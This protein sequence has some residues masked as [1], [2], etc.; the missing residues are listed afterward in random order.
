MKAE[1]TH[2][3]EE[4]DILL[5]K[6]LI[7]KLIIAFVVFSLVFIFKQFVIRFGIEQEKNTFSTINIAGR[8]RMLSQK[9]VKDLLMI[10]QGGGHEYTYYYEKD[11]ETSLLQWKE[12]QDELERR[13]ESNSFFQRNRITIHRMLQGMKDAHNQ[14]YLEIKLITDEINYVKTPIDLTDRLPK[15]LTMEKKI[16]VKF[17]KLVNQYELEAE[18]SLKMALFLNVS[19][20]WGMVAVIAYVLIK[21][22]IPL[23]YNLKSALWN[24]KDSRSNLMKM[25]HTMRGAILLVNCDGKIIF[26]NQ[27][28]EEYILKEKNPSEFLYL[29]SNMNWKEFNILAYIESVRKKD[30]R[31]K[32][33]EI[34]VGDREG[35]TRWIVLAA[36]YGKYDGG[37][38]VLIHFYDVTAQRQAEEAIKNVA[39]KDELT[40]LYNRHFLDSIIIDEFERARRYDLP[41]SGAL[42]DLDHFK[43]VNDTWGHPVGDAVLKHTAEIIHGQIRRSDYA[44][45]IGGEEFLILMPNTDLEGAYQN[46]EKIRKAV[47]DAEY[48]TVGHITASL[49]VGERRVDDNYQLLYEKID[50]ALY[51]AKE[52][53]RN[54]VKKATEEST[55]Y[56]A[57]SLRWK[58]KWD[59][60]EK[61]I[62]RQHQELFY[63]LSRLMKESLDDVDNKQVL[64][65]IDRIMEH[66]LQH[67]DYEETVLMEKK[68]TELNNHKQIHGNLIR[69]TQEIKSLV[70]QE[71]I[72]GLRAF[73]MIFEEVVADHLLKDDILF[74]SCISEEID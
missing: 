34:Q 10:H 68:Y 7:K 35:R 13:C 57:V 48:P 5:Y 31:P 19:L 69:R 26:K 30:Y 33:M 2:M 53:G 44:I 55:I 67:F 40:G 46:A 12:A 15:I 11:L 27:D 25:I 18:Q 49:G 14:F 3:N 62:D 58:K 23:L 72:N 41:L 21:I 28:A 4:Q 52:S 51:Q 54:C 50:K 59:C 43:R 38:S 17:D 64:E 1:E 9:M 70:S 24:A 74:F 71:E 39:S 22:F 32:E 65:K 63:L 56:A 47:E 29:T 45:R 66:L 37:E 16:L 73:S 36:V 42:L 61:T 60:G 8:Q 20:F 6:K